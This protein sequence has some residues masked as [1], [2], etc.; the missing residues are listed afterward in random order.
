MS[1]QDGYNG[2]KNYETWSVALILDN[3]EELQRAA[4]R[5]CE[6]AIAY[7]AP[8]EYWTEDMRQLYRSAD[9]L[10]DWV[11]RASEIHNG[12]TSD[13]WSFMWSQ[14]VSAALSDVDWESVA[15][16]YLQAIAEDVTA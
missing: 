14:L 7:G 6:D 3:D 15:R 13:P 2:W 12:I 5:V 8:S 11:E 16:H 1:D 9:A 10:K 4:V